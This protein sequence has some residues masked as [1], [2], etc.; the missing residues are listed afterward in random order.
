[1]RIRRHRPW[2][3]HAACEMVKNRRK[4]KPATED[5][6]PVKNSIAAKIV[7]VLDMVGVPRNQ[8]F[9]DTRNSVLFK[10]SPYQVSALPG[11]RYAQ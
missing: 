7:F 9:T 10:S 6:K 4:F 3:D 8:I 2:L 5:G 1:L 11:L